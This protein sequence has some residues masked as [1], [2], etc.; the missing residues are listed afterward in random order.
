MGANDTNLIVKNFD[1]KKTNRGPLLHQ[2]FSSGDPN[3]RCISA[4]GKIFQSINENHVHVKVDALYPKVEFWTEETRDDIPRV[5]FPSITAFPMFL[6][7]PVTGKFV[8]KTFI[9]SVME[10]FERFELCNEV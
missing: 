10:F 8:G 5:N 9:M 2:W 6:C 1:N 7:T 4:V 3:P